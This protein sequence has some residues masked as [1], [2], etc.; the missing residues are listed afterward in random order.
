M[1]LMLGDPR[2][3]FVPSTK[4]PVSL[5][6]HDRTAAWTAHSKTFQKF[7]SEPEFLERRGL[8]LNERV[9]LN[10]KFERSAMLK[11]FINRGVL[12]EASEA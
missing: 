10:P 12:F 7:P 1:S 11:V 6:S 2:F 9:V 3:S 8:S 4:A 5:E